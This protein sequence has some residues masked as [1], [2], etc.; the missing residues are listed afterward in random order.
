MKTDITLDTAT[1]L[2]ML[3][4]AIH[5]DIPK[6]NMR[7]FR[8]CL[9]GAMCR[10]PI[11]QALGLVPY[12]ESSLASEFWD[13]PY[14]NA[15]KSLGIT[16]GQSLEVFNFGNTTRDALARLDALIAHYEH[17]H[18][19]CTDKQAPRLTQHSN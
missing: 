7:R 14:I 8:T 16:T 11:G 9:L 13:H 17:G 5:D 4:D 18:T 6:I 3:R 1:K 12:D 15:A 10:T 2:C 19:F